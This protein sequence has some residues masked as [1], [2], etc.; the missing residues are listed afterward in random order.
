MTKE[1]EILKKIFKCIDTDIE[2]PHGTKE[3]I[4]Q[5][6]INESSQL[7][8]CHSSFNNWFFEKLFKLGIPVW[9]LLSILMTMF[10]SKVAS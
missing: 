8:F 4:Y 10:T 5:R 6:L 9:I 3:K 1:D 2:P 7:N